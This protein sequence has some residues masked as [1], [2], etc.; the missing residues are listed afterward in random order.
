MSLDFEPN[1]S[2]I[3]PLPALR[4]AQFCPIA[5]AAE[6]LGER[7][8]LLVVR[9]LFCGPQRFSDLRRRLPGLSSSMLAERLERLE[10][11]G[12]VRWRTLA[13]P[14]ASAVYELDEAGRDLEPALAELAR[15]GV[16]FLLPGRAGD[17]LEPDWVVLALQLFARREATPA[18]SFEIRIPH[19]SEEVVL[20]VAGGPEGTTVRPGPGPARV[21]LRGAARVILGV[22]SGR[23]A[24]ASAR[25]RGAL[26]IR[27]AV[28]EAGSLAEL[29]RMEPARAPEADRASVGSSPR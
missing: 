7:W 20:H 8:T 10:A 19:R 25:R 21:R 11:R 26:E 15:W 14:A 12:V 17:H 13:P 18:C 23:L 5:R 22:A 3:K 27:G 4:Y 24:P 29:F 28:S 1:N 9:E 2:K 16:R 6:V